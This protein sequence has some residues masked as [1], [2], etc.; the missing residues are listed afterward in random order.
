MQTSESYWQKRLSRRRIMQAGALAGTSAAAMALLGCSSG[1]GSKDDI[2]K[3]SNF[4]EPKDT[5]KTAKKGGIY[6]SIAAQDEATLDPLTTIRG[7]G[8]GGIEVYA[9]QKLLREK[10]QAYG[11]KATEYEG[12][13]AESY[14]LGDGGLRLTL[15][16][17]PNLKWDQ[18]A[19]TN[20][21]QATADDVIYSWNK[22][23]AQS[24]YRTQLDNKA[25][26]TAGVES[27]TKIDNLTVQFKMAF[28]W[29]PLIPALAWGPL[30]MAPME[31]EDKFD[32]RR[33]V[34][35][36]GPW[37]LEEYRA[38][39][40]FN[41]KRNP[42][43]YDTA[44]PYLDGVEEPILAE[45]AA[46]LAQ[47]KAKNIWDLTPNAEDVISIRRESPALQ[48]YKG[49]LGLTGRHLY[50][51]SNAGSPFKDV[52][53]RRAVSM[54]LDR[55]IYADIYTNATKFASEGFEI[56]YFLDNYIPAGMTTYWIDPRGKDMGEAAKYFA[57]NPADAKA[58]VQAAAFPTSQEMRIRW[59]DTHLTE[60]QASVVAEW[61]AAI[62]IKSKLEYA[63]RETVFNPQILVTKGKF[64]GDISGLTRPIGFDPGAG[65]YRT[66]HSNGANTGSA[67]DDDGQKKI[68]ALLERS[69]REVDTQKNVA[70][71][72]E[73]QKE[74][75]LYQGSIPINFQSPALTFTWPWV[76]NFGVY[77]ASEVSATTNRRIAY[78]NMWI[79]D[80]LKS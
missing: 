7:A 80:S 56:P 42:N 70:L 49:P 51:N 1:G 79:D 37:M 44:L 9:Y 43:Y 47:F 11:P 71:I 32:R 77:R 64:P 60:K 13:F 73:I 28:P 4:A 20:S 39:A 53:V 31:S 75:G 30:Q 18:R 59:T 17:R 19:P 12:D 38:S 24:P 26:P 58:L 52:R 45:Y 34:R 66:N 29:A 2:A 78:H 62:G 27:V 22:V 6:K 67:W 21:R 33:E 69:I 61:L 8:A 35:G 5:S 10:A 36:S 46:K 15:K 55:D 63:D 48:L 72:K 41:W 25:D 50:L 14:E 54:A 57:Y 3:V 23:A 65:L 40:L 68:D 76:M 16:I 74:L